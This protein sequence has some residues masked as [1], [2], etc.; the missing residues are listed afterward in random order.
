MAKRISHKPSPPVAERPLWHGL[1]TIGQ[2]EEKA[3]ITDRSAFWMPFA[4]IV[5]SRESI[6][7]GV[8]ELKRLIHERQKARPAVVT[9]KGHKG[10]LGR[11]YLWTSE[12]LPGIAVQ[13]CGHPTALRPYFIIGRKIRRKF[14]RLRDAQHAAAHPEEFEGDE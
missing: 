7:A 14:S 11:N 1:F 3:G 2:L 9:W 10:P 12:Q 6:D 5:D 8:A 4:K 13:H